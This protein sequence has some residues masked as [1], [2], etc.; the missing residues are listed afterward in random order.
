[1]AKKNGVWKMELDRFGYTLVVLGKTKEECDAAMRNEY[2][3]TYAKWNELDEQ[4]CCLAIEFPVADE[5]GE[6]DDGNPYN[7]FRRYYRA[8]FEDADPQFFEFGKVE[9]T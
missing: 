2:I 7:E 3:K 8:A 5:D 4:T 6:V 9:W 1:M